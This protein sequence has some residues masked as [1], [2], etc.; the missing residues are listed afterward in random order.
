MTES[1]GTWADQANDLAS[2]AENLTIVDGKVNGNKPKPQAETQYAIKW[3]ERVPVRRL[4]SLRAHIMPYSPLPPQIT[5]E[6]ISQICP[7]DLC[8]VRCDFDYVMPNGCDHN[9]EM[10]RLCKVSSL[11]LT[12]TLQPS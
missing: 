3:G 6:L 9:C 5:D 12:S 8:D 11:S 10:L 1:D 4:H 7:A 2:G